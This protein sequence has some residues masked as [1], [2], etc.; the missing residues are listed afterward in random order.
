MRSLLF[1]ITDSF[2]NHGALLDSFILGQRA[3]QVLAKFGKNT[4][5]FL[6]SISQHF[7]DILTKSANQIS[8]SHRRDHYRSSSPIIPNHPAHQT[9]RQMDEC[10]CYPR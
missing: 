3:A 6:V 4:D 7:Y 8:G 10:V 5:L 1:N 2:L 9:L